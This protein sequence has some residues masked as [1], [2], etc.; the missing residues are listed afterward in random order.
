MTVLTAPQAIGRLIAYHYVI[1]KRT[2]RGSV[3]I[4]IAN[5][6]LFLTGMGIGIGALI[7]SSGT[8]YLDVPYLTF[9]APGM[10]AAAAMQ[11]GY[12]G[13]GF[14]VFRA[15]SKGGSYNAAVYTPMNSSE[16][17]IGHQLATALRNTLFMSCFYIAALL[18]GATGSPWSILM[19][20]AS[21]LTGAA[22]SA[23][24]AAWAVTVRRGA[25]MQAVF[26]IVVQPLYLLSGTFFPLT[27]APGWVQKAAWISPLWH[28]VVVCRAVNVGRVGPGTYVHLAVLLAFVVVGLLCARVTYARRLYQ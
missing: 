28:G 10:M 1:Y 9:L 15:V 7:K 6:I 22:M 5:P 20:P 12:G 13:G 11:I 17:L 8:S 3:V 19:L 14:A 23:P 4:G 25:Q 24:V 21:V 26:R 16:L 2:W 18:L 27:T